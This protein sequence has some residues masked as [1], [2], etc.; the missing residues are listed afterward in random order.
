MPSSPYENTYTLEHSLEHSLGIL[1]SQVDGSA[2]PEEES[3]TNASYQQDQVHELA[4][5]DLNFLAALAAPTLFK[6]FFP[7][8]FISAWT[9]LL[10][11]VHKPRD[12]SKLALGL[13]RGFGK[14]TFVKFFII[15][16]ILFTKKRYILVISATEKHAINIITDVC[17]MLAS[18]NII[19][20]FGDYR[21]GSVSDTQAFKVFGFRSRTI[22]LEATGK[23]GAIRGTNRDNERPDVM[24]FEDIQTREEADSEA[25]S[26]S[27]EQWMLGTAMKAKSPA[28]CLYLFVANMYP[29]RFSIL[30]KLKTNPS[31]TKFI[32]G[33]IL[34]DGTSLW[35]DLQPIKQLLEE[36]QSDL[37]SGHPEIF[38]SEVLNDENANANSN[39]DLDKLPPY[40]FDPLEVSLGDYIIIDPSND[41]A[42]SDYVS[43]GHFRLLSTRS[44]D[45]KPVLMHLCEERLTPGDTIR[46]AYE[47]A[48][49]YDVSLIAVEANAYQYSLLYWFNFIGQQ[50]EAV[51]IECVP[52]YSGSLSK[53]TRILTM[54]K[55]Y[56]KGEIYVHPDIKVQ[57]HYQISQYKA[58]RRDNVDGILDLLTYA[59]RVH[60]EFGPYIA[61][62][63]EIGRQD[64]GSAR[65][66]PATENCSC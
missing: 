45:I 34:S 26:R 55:E 1:A 54:F 15:Y 36:F 17:T 59:G 38:Y 12:F 41:R 29:T 13:P 2:P 9:W 62:N 7:A 42:N 10:S 27:I 14:T 35:E 46:K 39:I 47:F 21:L 65:V 60:D 22:M 16:C 63:A 52:I 4:K 6:F 51:G 24:I 37:D 18:S 40:P 56:L 20:V 11:Y 44:G 25:V 32:V 28:G 64:Q 33:G 8:V 66:L 61:M 58:N 50:I 57:V 31:W 5:G 53:A 48:F 3:Q 43:I 49:L 30:R 23:C 19:A